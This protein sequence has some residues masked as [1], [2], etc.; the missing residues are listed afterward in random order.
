MRFS[1]LLF[2]N[3]FSPRS[4]HGSPFPTHLFLVARLGLPPLPS[5]TLP[6][7]DALVPFPP[8]PS[9]LHPAAD[10]SFFQFGPKNS[11]NVQTSRAVTRFR[12]AARF[13]IEGA[14]R[15]VDF[16]LLPLSSFSLSYF[17]TPSPPS[18]SFLPPWP[19]PM[20]PPTPLSSSASSSRTSSRTSS[21]LL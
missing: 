16:L 4:V 17:T 8:T 1:N 11:L 21:S 12:L 3:L 15:V 2:L 9:L 13:A 6:L 5:F 10:T 14:S 20:P 7:L 19:T 18:P